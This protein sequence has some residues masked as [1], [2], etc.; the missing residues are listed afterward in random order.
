M[1]DLRPFCVLCALLL[2]SSMAGSVALTAL[3]L[4]AGSMLLIVPYCV[5]IAV[6]DE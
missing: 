4:D 3:D 1:A 2:L 5:C 6:F